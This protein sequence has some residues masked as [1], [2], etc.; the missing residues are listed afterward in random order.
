MSTFA[1]ARSAELAESGSR[2]LD[3]ICEHTISKAV[4]VGPQDFA[5]F[6]PSTASKSPS[7]EGML[8]LSVK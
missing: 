4:F 8:K 2:G 3:R 1:S 7:S 5:L 6:Q